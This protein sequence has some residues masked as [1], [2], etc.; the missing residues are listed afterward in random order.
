MFAIVSPGWF[1]TRF[2]KEEYI[3]LSEKQISDYQHIKAAHE[4]FKST[5]GNQI[6]D[7]D[8]VADV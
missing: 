2:S 4:N 8:K 6:G 3:D 1:R 5:D 7:P